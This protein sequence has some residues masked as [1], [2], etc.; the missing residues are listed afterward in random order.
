MTNPFSDP[1]NSG[2]DERT[3]LRQ[4]DAAPR[5]KARPRKPN[6]EFGACCPPK[7]A[8]YVEDGHGA[9]IGGRSYDPRQ[10]NESIGLG[11]YLFNTQL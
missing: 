2:D 4:E 5:H 10:V 7:L 11:R 3:R 8:Q 6:A 1:G 9:R